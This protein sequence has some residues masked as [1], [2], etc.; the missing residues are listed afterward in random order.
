[1]PNDNALGSNKMAGTPTFG[2]VVYATPTTTEVSLHL[3]DASGDKFSQNIDVAN[4]A[5]EGDVDGL[6]D[7]YQAAS[8]ASLYKV[9]RIQSWVG[10]A[11]PDNAVAAYRG[12]ISDGTNMLFKNAAQFTRSLR[13]IAPIATV[14]QGNQDIPLLS[15]TEMVALI[16]DYLTLSSGFDLE[17]AQFTGRRERK[18]NPKIRV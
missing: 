4:T 16:T 2:G 14:M 15:A 8:N 7:S 3:I 17:S 13:L 11:D 10:V 18:N 5:A 9:Q 1:M 6:A 12:S